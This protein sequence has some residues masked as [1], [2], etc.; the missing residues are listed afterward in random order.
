M[1]LSDAAWATRPYGEVVG[2]A[3]QDG[4]LLVVPVGSLEQHG[5]HLPTATDTLLA[6]AVAHAAATAAAAPV[7]VTP[8]V[9][10]GFSPHHVPF[11]GTVSLA[12]EDLAGL[13]ESIAA[14]ALAEDFDALC[15][16]NG[17][18][19][20]GALVD[21]VSASVG[22]THPDV[23]VSSLTYFALAADIV[24]EVRDSPVG[25]MGHGGEFET[26]LMLHLHPDLVEMDRAE[27]TVMEEPYDLALHDLFASG[28]L[29]V[30]R[31]FDEYADSGA[32]GD[33]TVATV[34][35][36]EQL[37][38]HLRTALAGLFEEIHEHTRGDEG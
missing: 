27:G 1:R 26:S 10:S 24:D 18:S 14:A 5:H 33:P 30:Y 25:G 38:D 31:T 22:A 8:P 7:L 9:W 35:K 17:H 3:A 28:P 6:D 21:S 13:L 29:S 4:S 16:V 2:I 34:E 12:R 36:G 15:F 19:G 37:F 11:G 23:E 20:N 32:I